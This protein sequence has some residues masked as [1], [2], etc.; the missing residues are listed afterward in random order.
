MW[1]HIWDWNGEGSWSKRQNK[2]CPLLHVSK[3]NVRTFPRVSTH[4]SGPFV[5]KC[6]RVL[7]ET[8]WRTLSNFIEEGE[9]RK[10]SLARYQVYGRRTYCQYFS[11]NLEI[12]FCP[13]I[14]FCF[15]LITEKYEVHK[16]MR[17]FPGICLLL[18]RLLLNGTDLEKWRH[19]ECQGQGNLR[20]PCV[21][22]QPRDTHI[23]ET[24]RMSSTL[25][26]ASVCHRVLSQQINNRK[27]LLL[28]TYIKKGEWTHWN[29]WKP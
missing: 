5:G 16:S 1:G 18:L 7:G 13:E 23:C 14:H 25:I 24:V 15:S 22:V 21:V 11:T 6:G 12:L 20:L 4:A 29:H 9:V 27:M 19:W 3:S 26:G 2:L 17:K 10:I 8:T 28:I